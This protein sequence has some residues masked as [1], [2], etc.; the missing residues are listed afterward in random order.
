[1]KPLALLSR[2]LVL[3]ALVACQSSTDA[4]LAPTAPSAI[5]VVTDTAAKPAQ[6]SDFAIAVD[7]V[8]DTRAYVTVTWTDHSG[9]TAYT[10]LFTYY[11]GA[12]NNQAVAAPGVTSITTVLYALRAD[13]YYL[14]TRRY[15]SE[16]VKVYSDPVGPVTMFASATTV[17]AAGKR[18]K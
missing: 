17:A 11:A 15:I 5:V 12:P 1:M 7:S 14:R 9:G 8:V 18:K 6:P 3:V 10:D 13:D 16:G 4:T 2:S